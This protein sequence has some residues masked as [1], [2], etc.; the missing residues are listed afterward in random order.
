[1][2]KKST[3]TSTLLKPIGRFFQ[4]FHLTVFIVIIVGGLAYAVLSLYDVLAAASTLPVSATTAP[5]STSFDQSTINRLNQLYSSDKAPSSVTLPS[6]RINP[7][8]E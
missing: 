5:S 3:N 4:R 1:M 6:G 8:G 7:F 2:M